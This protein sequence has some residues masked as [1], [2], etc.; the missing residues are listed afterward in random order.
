M[1]TLDCTAGILLF[2]WATSGLFSNLRG[3][4]DAPDGSLVSTEPCGRLGSMA[5]LALTCKS[6]PALRTAG[7]QLI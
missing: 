2:S 5:Q 4:A 3:L 1:L 6:T 7:K